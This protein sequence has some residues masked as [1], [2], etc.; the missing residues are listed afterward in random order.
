MVCQDRAIRP[1]LPS[2]AE[3]NTINYKTIMV[4]VKIGK[5]DKWKLTISVSD[6]NGKKGNKFHAV[7]SGICRSLGIP[8]S[9]FKG[10]L[11][12]AMMQVH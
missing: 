10:V 9:L 4:A 11:K 6:L 12:K 1:S 2:G 5:K 7:G 8:A 3:S